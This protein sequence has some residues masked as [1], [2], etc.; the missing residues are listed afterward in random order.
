MGL[1][2]VI[3][4]LFCLFCHLFFCHT[5]LT[6]SSV[7]LLWLYRPMQLHLAHPNHPEQPYSFKVSWLAIL[8]PTAESLLPYDYNVFTAL[9]P[10]SK[11]HGSYLDKTSLPPKRWFLTRPG[12][13]GKIMLKE[14][15]KPCIILPA[16]WKP[17]GSGSSPPPHQKKINT[18]VNLIGQDFMPSFFSALYFTDRKERLRDQVFTEGYKLS[19]WQSNENTLILSF[20]HLSMQQPWISP[21]V[22]SG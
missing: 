13:K 5:S 4:H 10:G 9:I 17:P 22:I 12:V 14:H 15:F 11:V 2:L 8:I 7:F 1:V 21:T 6:D 19:L 3:L 18:E 20:I 16:L